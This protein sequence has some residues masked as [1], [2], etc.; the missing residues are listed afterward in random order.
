M[1]P[2][3]QAA[4]LAHVRMMNFLHNRLMVL[5]DIATELSHDFEHGGPTTLGALTDAVLDATCV[6]EEMC[7]G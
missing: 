6:R 2:D 7:R 3:R 4:L 5:E 1:D